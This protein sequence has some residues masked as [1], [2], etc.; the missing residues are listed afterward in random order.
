MSCGDN[1]FEQ[2]YHFHAQNHRIPNYSYTGPHLSTCS[3][4]LPVYQQILN[5]ESFQQ[6]YGER[7]IIEP[8][9]SR[10]LFSRMVD[11]D[12]VSGRNE[13]AGGRS[14]QTTHDQLQQDR[15]IRN[16]K[17]RIMS[18]RNVPRQRTSSNKEAGAATVRDINLD[19]AQL[20]DRMAALRLDPVSEQRINT[21]TNSMAPTSIS[22]TTP[23]DSDHVLL[24]QLH[25]RPQI[26]TQTATSAATFTP[27]AKYPSPP[28]LEGEPVSVLQRIRECEEAEQAIE[29]LARLERGKTLTGRYATL[30]MM[31]GY[32][33]PFPTPNYSPASSID[34]LSDVSSVTSGEGSE[35]KYSWV[36][37]GPAP[38][39]DPI[40]SWKKTINPRHGPVLYP[41][42]Q[43]VEVR[44]NPAVAPL[45]VSKKE[46]TKSQASTASVKGLATQQSATTPRT[47]ANFPQNAQSEKFPG[48][49][50]TA[51]SQPQQ[52]RAEWWQRLRGSQGTE[53]KTPETR[54][55]LPP[56]YP[57]NVTVVQKGEVWVED[58][59]KESFSD[60]GSEMTRGPEDWE[61]I[62]EAELY[63]Q[64]E[65]DW[66]A[67]KELDRDIATRDQT[68]PK[69]RKYI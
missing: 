19:H 15:V 1:E 61:V 50:K 20:P 5:T 30:P 38:E 44:G 34:S 39:T 40:D 32:E 66:E 67:V 3:R 12:F 60:S 33:V 28:K 29:E 7:T 55:N 2:Q 49:L 41:T 37:Q 54:P 58:I 18:E 16:E 10:S 62:E 52:N 53:T 57:S 24:A 43:R 59:Y 46:P 4:A 51:I 56:P 68:E 35:D 26:I 25:S 22:G 6:N 8:R 11:G 36:P 48:S 27:G 17:I 9:R 64:D 69:V 65:Q 13:R 23:Q 45:L 21:P 42:Y 47:P 31:S 14:V 63:E